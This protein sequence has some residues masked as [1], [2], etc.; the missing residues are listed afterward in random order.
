[1]SNNLESYSQCS[2]L[3][4]YK[5]LVLKIAIIIELFLNICFN[6]AKLLKQLQ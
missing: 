1:M 4:W 2:K 3:L 5:M 6:W